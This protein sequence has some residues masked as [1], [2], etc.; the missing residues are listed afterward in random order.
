MDKFDKLLIQVI[1]EVIRYSLGDINANIIYNYLQ[2]KAC[3]LT[4][5]PNNLESFSTELRNLLG[6]G[7]G[8]ILGSAHLLERT[9]LK[10]LCI[11]LGIKYEL[12]NGPIIF[13]EHVKKIKDVYSH[14]NDTFQVLYEN[15][16]VNAS[17]QKKK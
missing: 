4:E 10:A 14:E 9:I 5:I 8:Q 3:P 1:D 2:K 13:A 15:V 11:K 12:E 16:E 7:R 6:S 17:C